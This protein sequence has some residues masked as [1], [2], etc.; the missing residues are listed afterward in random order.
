[1]KYEI[2]EP[3]LLR[4]KKLSKLNE[5]SLKRICIN[6]RNTLAWRRYSKHKKGNFFK[7]FRV[8]KRF[9]ELKTCILQK[10]LSEIS[11]QKEIRI[12]PK[13]IWLVYCSQAFV[14]RSN[15]SY[16]EAYC[17]CVKTMA[18]SCRTKVLQISSSCYLPLSRIEDPTRCCKQSKTPGLQWKLPKM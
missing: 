8:E 9:S 5:V 14:A 1:M 13:S 4:K 18:P 3:T 16:I 10:R 2:N 7:Y 6:A 12:H 11:F 17:A 15:T